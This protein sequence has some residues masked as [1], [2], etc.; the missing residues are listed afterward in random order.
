VNENTLAP[1]ER[2]LE[3]W[4]VEHF[5]M[6]GNVYDCELVPDY[7]REGCVHFTDDTFLEPYF[8]QLLARQLSVPNGRIDLVGYNS[9]SVCAVEIKKGAITYDTLGQC[10]RYIY[11]LKQIF[12]AVWFDCNS[13][14]NPN[15]DDFAAPLHF[16]WEV[17]DFAYCQHEVSGML[18]GS[19][20]ADSNL[21]LVAAT[22]GI[23]VVTYE[24]DG[25]NYWF[26]HQEMSSKGRSADYDEYAH[27]V[28][29]E[30]F[31]NILRRRAAWEKRDRGN[32]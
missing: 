22:C 8:D 1:S 28:L 4:I 15:R 17:I 12:N 25:K 11:D 2:H 29:G 27:G 20:I 7:A 16:D 10:V 21:S 30:A 31:R 24:F 14:S 26:E 3:D 19:S 9:K 32:A 6:L 5:D 23:A 13:S 18:V